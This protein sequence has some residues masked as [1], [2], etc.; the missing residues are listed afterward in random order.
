MHLE[1]AR[2][3]PVSLAAL[4]LALAAPRI[5]RAADPDPDAGLSAGPVVF[6]PAVQIAPGAGNAGLTSNGDGYL[7]DTCAPG[8]SS[9]VLR[10]GRDGSSRD[11]ALL[12]SAIDC[13]SSHI[14]SIAGGYLLASVGVNGFLVQRVPAAGDLEAFVPLLASNPNGTPPSIACAADRCLIAW[15]AYL[16]V[17]GIFVDRTGAAIGQGFVIYYQDSPTSSVHPR[18]FSD[19]SSF[20]VIADHVYHVGADGSATLVDL[21][22]PQ[23]PF[24]VAWLG[25]RYEMAMHDGTLVRTD[26]AGALLEPATTFV[27]PFPDAT[28]VSVAFDGSGMFV[29]VRSGPGDAGDAARTMGYHLPASGPVPAITPVELFGPGSSGNGA[30]A[31]ASSAP[32]ELLV[33]DSLPVAGSS[34]ARTVARLGAAPVAPNPPDAGSVGAADAG[35]A[36]ASTSDAAGAA[37]NATGAA[38]GGCGCRAVGRDVSSTGAAGGIA[39]L[40]AVLLGVRRRRRR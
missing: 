2:F 5:A 12:G 28:D 38:G 3:A 7:V 17:S 9:Q 14:A 31:V 34:N 4:A 29:V 25:D 8:G 10:L 37:T 20:L 22:S 16:Q 24:A 18:V 15:N 36:D 27:D 40:G 1:L 11:T 23:P 39:F 6:G 32:G 33:V 30:R 13:E 35:P 19:G 21:P 26:A